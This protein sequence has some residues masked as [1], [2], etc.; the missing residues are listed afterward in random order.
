MKQHKKQ[1]E[2]LNEPLYLIIKISQVQIKKKIK[3]DVY[4][5]MRWSDETCNIIS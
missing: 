1:V 2:N 3:T 4:W 5:V